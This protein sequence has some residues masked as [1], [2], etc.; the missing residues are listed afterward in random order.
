[1]GQQISHVITITC[2]ITVCTYG[3]VLM[4]MLRLMSSLHGTKF[5]LNTTNSSNSKNLFWKQKSATPICTVCKKRDLGCKKAKR[6]EE[7]KGNGR[8]IYSHTTLRLQQRKIL[9]EEI[10]NPGIAILPAVQLNSM[11]KTGTQIVC[12]SPT[13]PTPQRKEKRNKKDN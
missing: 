6:I 10:A 4:R 2:I 8:I 12:P 11:I 9:K 1:M 3:W 13:P 5:R 7:R